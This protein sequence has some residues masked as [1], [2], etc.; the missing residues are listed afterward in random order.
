MRDYHYRTSSIKYWGKGSTVG[1]YK[2]LRSLL[3]TVCFD[4][5]GFS[6]VVTLKSSGGFLPCR[7]SLFVNKSPCQ[8]IFCCIFSLIGDLF[9]LPCIMHVNLYIYIYI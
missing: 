4:N 6:R 5:S 9:V 7:F 3:V 8:F 1:W 2:V